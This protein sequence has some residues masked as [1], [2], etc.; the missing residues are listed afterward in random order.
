MAA[1]LLAWRGSG[2]GAA[3]QQECCLHAGRCLAAACRCARQA[4]A[5]ASCKKLQQRNARAATQEQLAH[6]H[7]HP[8]SHDAAGC[9]AWCSSCCAGTGGRAVQGA[10]TSQVS[11]RPRGGCCSC[12]RLHLQ[13]FCRDRYTGAPFAGFMEPC[14]SMQVFAGVAGCPIPLLSRV[15]TG[16][17]GP[18]MPGRRCNRSPSQACAQPMSFTIPR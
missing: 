14:S 15:H 3:H 10:W 11:H 2:A 16:N 18:G 12:R 7:V 8:H 4:A 9:L 13:G 17:S 6:A 5:G 1:R